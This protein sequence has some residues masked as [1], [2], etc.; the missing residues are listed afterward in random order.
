MVK[1]HITLL[2]T[3]IFRCEMKVLRTVNEV[4]NG[5]FRDVT[6]CASCKNRR[7]GGT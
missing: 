2:S 1:R 5:V 4:N 3:D 7:F 6:T